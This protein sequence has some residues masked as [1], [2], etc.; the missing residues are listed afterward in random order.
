MNPDG[1]LGW[2]GRNLPDT[3][4]EHLKSYLPLE[5]LVRTAQ[6]NIQLRQAIGPVEQT[7]VR[8][9]Y[10][11]EGLKAALDDQVTVEVQLWPEQDVYCEITDAHQ[12]W[13]V[14]IL[15]RGATQLS[16]EG[17][18]QVFVYDNV[19]VDACDK[20]RNFAEGNA[21]IDAYNNAFITV[22][23]DNVTVTAHD[24]V[25]VMVTAPNE[26]ITTEDNARV[27]RMSGQ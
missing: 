22:T 15:A 11:Q 8:T 23:S 21:V 25:W 1:L 3:V 26:R 7:D 16:A 17:E 4:R 5:D 20:A 18:S 24:D 2:S 9:V 14:D 19:K 12:S 27:L 6:A 13:E 10:T